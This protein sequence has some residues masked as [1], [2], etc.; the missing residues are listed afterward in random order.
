MNLSYKYWRLKMAFGAYFIFSLCVWA[1]MACKLV[2]SRHETRIA[3]GE[4]VLQIKEAK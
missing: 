3:K 4:I 1:F 2:Q